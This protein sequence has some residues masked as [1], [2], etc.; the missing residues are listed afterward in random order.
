M[1]KG[2][3]LNITSI[4]RKFKEKDRTAGVFYLYLSLLALKY[5]WENRRNAGSPLPEKDIP[6]ELNTLFRD[7]PFLGTAARLD[8][9][10]SELG[11][12]NGALER[13]FGNISF[14]KWVG[15]DQTG[16][17]TLQLQRLTE[18]IGDITFGDTA[19][20]IRRNGAGIGYLLEK[21]AEENFHKSG[22]LYTPKSL[23]T[24]MARI[25][26]PAREDQLYDPACGLGNLLIQA[27]ADSGLNGRALHGAES[28]PD[29]WQLAQFNLFF[30]G[31]HEAQIL[32]QDSL[33]ESRKTRRIAEPYDCVLLHPPFTDA[34][35]LPAVTDRLP[36]LLNGASEVKNLRSRSVAGAEEDFLSLLLRS[37]KGSGRGA[38][39]VP[40]G[41]LFKMGS[42]A[43]V[44]KI[45]IDHNVVEAV[46]DLPPNI[47]Y[48]S[49]VNVA[50]LVL[51]KAKAHSDI[52]FV[53]GSRLYEP[54]R[55]RNKMRLPHIDELTRLYRDFATV[56]FMASR[57]PVEEV[58]QEPNDYNLTVRRYVWQ[59]EGEG[60]GRD[61][62]ALRQ[63][64]NDLEK[65][66]Q[67]LH[68]QLDRRIHDFVG[69]G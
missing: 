19:E 24:L 43:Q 48:S 61:I 60:V 2:F 64:L 55:R 44:R 69:Q 30:N 26:N 59:P 32:L 25:I 4:Y 63:E 50:V 17:R 47:F 45:L 54:D 67:D 51:N 37:L 21:F 13:L 33:A 15:K 12:V 46:I 9:I 31:L 40:H 57:V 28:D 34:P 18:D 7:I 41:V 23:S 56:P 3:L 5:I 8:R 65:K 22:F 36:Y 62:F 6:R 35:L 1:E 68:Q 16:S 20:E 42:A 14:V 39:I 53:D 49:K 38:M 10:I 29:C 52:L 58:Q 11:R 66:L 27:A